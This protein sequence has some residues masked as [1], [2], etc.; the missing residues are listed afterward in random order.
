MCLFSPLG[1]KII[2]YRLKKKNY[3]ELGLNTIFL[4]LE[5]RIE[6]HASIASQLVLKPPQLVDPNR[7]ICGL[8][9]TSNGLHLMRH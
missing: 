5:I 8:D 4:L 7:L 9:T 6:Y 1:I 3:W 2:S